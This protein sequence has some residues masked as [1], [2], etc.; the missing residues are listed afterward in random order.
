MQ[1]LSHLLIVILCHNKLFLLSLSL[2]F[3]QLK[4]HL[5][6]DI[7]CLTLLCPGY[8]SRLRAGSGMKK[9]TPIITITNKDVIVKV[10]T[11]ILYAN[12]YNCNY[13][14]TALYIDV[15]IFL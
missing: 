9:P 11:L 13:L 2:Y 4:I 12:C 1:C 8:L 3:F 5:S 14:V 7:L 15:V 6:R 10:G